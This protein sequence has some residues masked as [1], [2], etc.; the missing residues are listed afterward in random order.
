MESTCKLLHCAKFS[1][2]KISAKSRLV[3][4]WEIFARFIST[5][6]NRLGGIKFQ[7]SSTLCAFALSAL[8]A[9]AAAGEKWIARRVME[10][11]C[12]CSYHVYS[13]IWEA[14]IGKE[15]NCQQEPSNATDQYAVAVVMSGTVVG[16]SPMKLLHISS[17]FIRSCGVL[18]RCYVAGGG[19]TLI[20]YHKVDW[21]S[22]AF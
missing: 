14:T 12:V 2:G 7:G 18:S 9:T 13:D 21:R 22:H 17:L 5:H 4:F 10:K 6:A 8:K 3:A 20:T 19:G 1:L 11:C 16:R 15:L